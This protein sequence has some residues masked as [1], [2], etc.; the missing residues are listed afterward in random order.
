MCI[1]LHRLDGLHCGGGREVEDENW[2]H[3]RLSSRFFKE[4]SSLAT[5][6]STLHTPTTGRARTRLA[7][8]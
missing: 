1:P 5:R 4:N 6:T 8:A 2:G 3:R 7:P